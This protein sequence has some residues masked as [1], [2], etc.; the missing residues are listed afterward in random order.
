MNSKGNSRLGCL[1]MA[2]ALLLSISVTEGVY[3]T[4]P[5]EGDWLAQ[6]ISTAT[7]VVLQIRTTQCDRGAKNHETPVTGPLTF[8]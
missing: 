5:A 6:T 4:L 1:K 2:V 7:T 8:M 3:A